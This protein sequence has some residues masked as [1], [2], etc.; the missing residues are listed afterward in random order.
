MQNVFLASNCQRAMLCATI[1]SILQANDLFL[2]DVCDNGRIN[3]KLLYIV[4][5]TVNILLNNYCK[6][7]NDNLTS[8]KKKIEN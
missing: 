2:I 7:H 1:I 3:E 5:T 6:Q 8:Q 4:K